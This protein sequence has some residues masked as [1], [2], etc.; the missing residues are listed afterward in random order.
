MLTPM[1][2]IVLLTFAIGIY[3]LVLRI[4]SVSGGEVKIKY[5]R[6]MQGQ[7]IPE[8]VIKSTRCFNNMFE[9][10]V[11]FYA[12]CILWIVYG[13][14]STFAVYMAW[15]YVLTRIIH[16]IIHL[17]YNNVLHRMIMFLINSFIVLII[18]TNLVV[19]VAA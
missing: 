9:M 15:L 14:Q 11:L 16:T 12:A 6:T 2:C 17:T 7:D 19:A 8:N 1:F 18:W 13:L 3:T 4:R 5:Y 10:P